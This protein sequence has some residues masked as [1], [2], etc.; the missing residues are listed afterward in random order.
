M[1]LA[2]TTQCGSVLEL[3]V[4]LNRFSPILPL[5]ADLLLRPLTLKRT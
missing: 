1:A 5:F 2:R 3:E 4:S